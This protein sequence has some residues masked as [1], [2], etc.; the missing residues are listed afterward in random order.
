MASDRILGNA[1]GPYAWFLISMS[2]LLA[3]VSA[4]EWFRWGGI[5]FAIGAVAIGGLAV[6]GIVRLRQLSAR[7]GDRDRGH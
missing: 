1:R 2:L 4:V 3:V 7:D 6:A 5:L